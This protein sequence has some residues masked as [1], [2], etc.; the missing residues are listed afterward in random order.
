[1]K[2]FILIGRDHKGAPWSFLFGDYDRET[3]EFEKYLSPKSKLVA[4]PSAEQVVTD[5][6]I[7]DLNAL[8]LRQARERLALV[9]ALV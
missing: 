4:L 7:L 5:Q 3:V 9:E 6:Y 1:M 2:Y 8:E